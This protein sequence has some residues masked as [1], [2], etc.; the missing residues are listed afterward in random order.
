MRPRLRNVSEI[1]FFY[2]GNLGNSQIRQGQNLLKEVARTNIKQN[3]FFI[4]L[5]I[6][7]ALLKFHHKK[8]KLFLE[9]FATSDGQKIFHMNN[10]F[11]IRRW[12]N[13]FP[14][15]TEK[16][17]FYR[18]NICPR[19]MEKYLFYS[20]NIFPSDVVYFIIFPYETTTKKNN[21]RLIELRRKSQHKWEKYFF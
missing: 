6:S 3:A 16:Y 8:I 14:R 13:I 21:R 9:I 5:V 1:P 18:T 19:L 2:Q 17:L 10:F 15:L 12:T 7:L 20:T 11:V 4:F